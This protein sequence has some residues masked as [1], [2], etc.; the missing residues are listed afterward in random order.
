MLRSLIYLQLSI[1]QHKRHGSN[2]IVQFVPSSFVGI[3][4]EN[5]IFPSVC[6]FDVVKNYQ[7]YLKALIYICAF[8]S[9]MLTNVPV[10]YV[11]PRVFITSPL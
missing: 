8:S 3:I 6:I 5:A 7:V 2:F 4:L 10:L 9:F 11:H 1:V